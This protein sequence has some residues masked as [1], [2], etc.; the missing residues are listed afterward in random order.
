MLVIS[1]VSTAL[2]SF[3]FVV[4]QSKDILECRVETLLE[5]ITN[6]RLFDVRPGEPVTMEEFSERIKSALEVSAKEL[7]K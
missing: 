5:D 1:G 7:N 2:E 3:D 6:L 4:K